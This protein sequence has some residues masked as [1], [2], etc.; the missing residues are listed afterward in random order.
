MNVA[1]RTNLAPINR[2]TRQSSLASP[3]GSDK[4]LILFNLSSS[5]APAS[6]VIFFTDDVFEFF[7]SRT[8]NLV[9]RGSRVESFSRLTATNLILLLLGFLKISSL[10]TVRMMVLSGLY[11]LGGSAHGPG[12]KLSCAAVVG[13]TLA[14][15]GLA[16][17]LTDARPQNF[18][19]LDMALP[20]TAGQADL[21]FAEITGNDR[22]LPAIVSARSHDLSPSDKS[23]NV[24]FTGLWLHLLCSFV[25]PIITWHFSRLKHL[26]LIHCFIRWNF[27]THIL[28]KLT[29]SNELLIEALFCRLWIVQNHHFY[30]KHP[31][32]AILWNFYHL[33]FSRFSTKL[34]LRKFQMGS[35]TASSFCAPCEQNRALQY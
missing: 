21:V 9:S 2:H 31:G 19:D 3:L 28:G 4:N 16:T 7:S 26:K 10:L 32:I 20:L 35:Q 13:L 11:L 14:F 30:S 23:I 34:S 5:P 29:R 8:F 1:F 6:S 17:G 22:S 25:D 18:L 24:G 27:E 33:F 15:L 12:G